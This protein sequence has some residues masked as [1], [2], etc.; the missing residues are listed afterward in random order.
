MTLRIWHVDFDTEVLL[1]PDLADYTSLLFTNKPGLATDFD[2]A[3]WITEGT[4]FTYDVV[5]YGTTFGRRE[6]IG[7]T[8]STD[9]IYKIYLKKGY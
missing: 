3:G 5:D 2:I 6:E 9:L 7:T 1:I 8:N 4:F